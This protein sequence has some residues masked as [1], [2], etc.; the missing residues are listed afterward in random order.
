MIIYRRN[1]DG[2]TVTMCLGAVRKSA[3][4]AYYGL[5]PVPT[6]GA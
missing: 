3:N 6:K 5:R 2:I 4:D 1:P